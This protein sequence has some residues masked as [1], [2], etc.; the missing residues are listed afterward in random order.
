MSLDTTIDALRTVVD[1]I[2]DLNVYTDPPESINQFPSAIVYSQGGDLQFGSSGLTRNYHTLVVEIYHA[3]QRLP[4]AID[5]AKAWPDLMYSAISDAYA[6]GTIDVVSTNG[7]A[8]ISYVSR[9]L[10]YNSVVH[11]GVRFTVRLKE[12]VSG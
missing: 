12:I 10:Q 9:P 1:T 3:T 11:F 4:Q 6:A 5:A 7:R 8:E 2:A